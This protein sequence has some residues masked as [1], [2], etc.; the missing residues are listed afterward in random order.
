LVPTF[1][2]LYRRFKHN[3]WGCLGE[4]RGATTLCIYYISKNLTPVEKNYIV[5]EKEF[6]VVV[7]AIN[8]FHHYITGYS[9]FVHTDHSAI[10]YLMNKPVT[11]GRVTR[12]LLLLQ[13]FDISIIDKPGRENVVVD[14]LSRL[15]NEGEA[16]P[17][18]DT[19]LDEHLFFF[20]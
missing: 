9:V 15:T 17:V 4:E 13:E 5:T 8:K 16:I 10:H 11:N 3:H 1:P 20:H 19:F 12:W 7:Y 2:Y 6:L 18:E 14:F